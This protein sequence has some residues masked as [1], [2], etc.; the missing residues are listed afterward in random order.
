MLL[1]GNFAFGQYNFNEIKICHSKEG[2]LKNISVGEYEVK[3]NDG[4][5]FFFSSNDDVVRYEADEKR[6]LIRNTGENDSMKL[7]LT[8]DGPVLATRD[9]SLMLNSPAAVRLDSSKGDDVVKT[10]YS[11]GNF[12]FAVEFTNNKISKISFAG[13]GKFLEINLTQVKKVY[14]WDVSIESANHANK[15]LL[16][17]A[18]NKPYLL[19]ISDDKNKVGVRLTAEKKNGYFN[20]LEG[21]RIF[22]NNSF[23][24]DEGYKLEYAANAKLKKQKSKFNLGCVY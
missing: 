11:L 9:T 19:S 5:L 15:L 1:I 3:I 20:L 24:P 12:S 2:E 4:A 17:S 16:T 18:Y 7:Q 14:T 21:G 13:T 6:F 22:G 23:A 10:L 8:K